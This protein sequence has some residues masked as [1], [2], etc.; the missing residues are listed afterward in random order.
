MRLEAL[1]QGSIRSVLDRLGLSPPEIPVDRPPHRELGDLSS[2]IA[3]LLTK[4]LKKPPQGVAEE[5]AKELSSHPAF[6][7]VQAVQGFLNFRL[8]PQTLHG[9]LKEILQEGLAYG[10]GEEGRGKRLQVEFVSSN[11]TGPLTIGHGRQAALGDVLAN[12]FSELGF[13]VTREYYLNDEG[14]QIELLAQ[15]LWARYRQALGDPKPIPEGG[16]HGDYLIPIGEEL[17]QK[18]GNA[19][20]EWN[21]EAKKVFREEVVPRMLR[22]IEEDLEAIGVSFD[23]WTREGDIIRKGLVDEV[24][25]RLREGG[26]VYEKDGAI[27]LSAKIHGLPRDP[28]LIRSDGTPTYLMVDIA[29]HLD[30]FRRGFDWVVDVQGA[31]HVEEQQEVKLALRLL[32]IPENFL[33]YCLHQFVTLKGAEGI[34]KMSTRAGRFLRLKDLVDEVGRDAT[35][36]FMVMRK[37]ES[38]LV[39]D[40]ALAKKQSLENPVYYVQYAHTRIASVFREAQARG[41]FPEDL[42]SLDL[43]PLTEPEELQL[44][45][46]LDRF[47]DV[48]RLA[49]RGFSPHLLC[50]YLEN[51][52]GIFHPYYARVRILGQGRATPARLAL[53][54]G[55]KLVLFRGLSILGVRAPE[56]M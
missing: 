48:V 13:Q 25:R 22:M 28:V 4:E 46:E 31:D 1:V 15:S 2:R 43:S 8:R 36:Y 9:V 7:Q 17:A 42:L 6:S 47:P 50:E 29:Y 14:R 45:M 55:V 3:F 20:P 56:E 18:F 11:P 24:L 41:E 35:R 21:A 27:W 33:S 40:F 37:P 10:K 12:L 19:Y 51:L 30:K 44:I 39:F 38:H 49:A 52:A 5:L 26:H 53:L 54:F 32:G 23:V 16:Y 34:E